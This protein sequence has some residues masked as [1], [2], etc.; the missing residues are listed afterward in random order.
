V[1]TPEGKR[2]LK[3]IRRGWKDNNKMD[4]GEIEWG[5]MDWIK[6]A[7]DRGQWRGLVNT[8]MNFRLP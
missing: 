6:V 5:S 3:R 1:A 2:P 8:V 7:Q 4:L